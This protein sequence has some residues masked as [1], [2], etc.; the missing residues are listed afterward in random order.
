MSQRQFAI[1]TGVS[2]LLM[3]VAAGFAVGFAYPQFYQADQFDFLKD[4]ILSNVELYRSMLN[5]I[6]LILILDVLVSYTLYKYFEN[7]N[8]K[9]SLLSGIVRFV[10]TVIFAIGTFFLAKNMNSNEHT[11]ELINS[12]FE[13]FQ[14]IWNG[15]L[16]IFGFHVVLIGWLMMLHKGIPKVLWY[17]TL[18]AGVSYIVV[19][20][21]KLTSSNLSLLSNV[22]MILALPMALGELGLAIWLLVKG[23]KELSKT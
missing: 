22:E 12:N 7:D 14:T 2:L 4:N 15:G 16:V 8:R 3:A 19:H 9:I 17:L 13:Q 23:G 18:F 6:L 10:Y 21:L 5:G 11:N 20:L 1:I